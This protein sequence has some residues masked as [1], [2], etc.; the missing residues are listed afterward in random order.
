MESPR[1]VVVLLV[2]LVLVGCTGIHA[3]LVACTFSDMASGKNYDLSALAALFSSSN[4]P[5]QTGQCPSSH[6]P[7]HSHP[8]ILSSDTDSPHTTSRTPLVCR[9]TPPL[10][11]TCTT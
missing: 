11:A 6:S 10:R 2:L 4:S 7:V 3:Q 9:Q 8:L 1:D 5:S